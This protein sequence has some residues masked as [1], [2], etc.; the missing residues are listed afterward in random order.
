M[1]HT[2]SVLMIAIRGP[3]READ[4]KKATG[5]RIPFV[6]FVHDLKPGVAPPLGD[7]C[8]CA[9]LWCGIGLGFCVGLVLWMVWGVTCWFWRVEGRV[10]LWWFPREMAN[11]TMFLPLW[12][13][14]PAGT[15]VKRCRASPVYW[16]IEH[17]TVHN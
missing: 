3:G 15:R 17:R 6:P 13:I 2:R 14:L 9:C 5:V 7:S 1:F 8:A 16:A 11:Q 10:E 12:K 4:L